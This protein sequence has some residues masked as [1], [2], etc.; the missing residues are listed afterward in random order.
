M[1]INTEADIWGRVIDPDR[2]SIAL[3]VARYILAMD[4]SAE[5][6]KRMDEL[7]SKSRDGTLTSEEGFELESY[8]H[9]SH[10]LA[11]MQSGAR[12]S[13]KRADS[14]HSIRPQT[15]LPWTSVSRKSRPA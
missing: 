14:L 2:N 10:V 8:R 1:S 3:E 4:F 11:R 9:V 5:D 7:A 12:V 13:L 6:K 15:T